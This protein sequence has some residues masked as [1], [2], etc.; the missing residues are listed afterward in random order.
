MEILFF[1][2]PFLFL[3][4]IA[5]T[6][7]TT[8]TPTV[9]WFKRALKKTKSI[10][11]SNQECE[12]EKTIRTFKLYDGVWVVIVLAIFSLT[13]TAFG[14]E[15]TFNQK[16][17]AFPGVAWLWILIL[18]KIYKIEVVDSTTIIFRGLFRKIKV[19]PK[20]IISVQDW[21]RGI[22]IVLKGRS[23]IL[24]PFID[25]L[26]EFKALVRGLN[27]EVTIKDMS[28]VATNSITRAGLIVIG[29]FLYFAWLIWSLF[30]SFT[31]NLG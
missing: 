28:N 9:A 21:L 11:N 17:Y 31:Q 14:P 24:F 7:D 25:K 5:L 26:G 16:V 29:V 1:I 15:K 10:K 13:Y 19:H 2:L 20:E 4:F 27:P 6:Y 22:R 23:I 12:A 18:F 8:V 30:K 3:V